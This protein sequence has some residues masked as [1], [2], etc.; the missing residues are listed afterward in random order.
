VEYADV[1]KVTELDDSY[2][3]VESVVVLEN[4]RVGPDKEAN[5]EASGLNS[6]SC[7][8]SYN[9]LYTNLDN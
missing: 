6:Y 2:T 1:Y 5:T 7:C 8:W 9:H 4:V 3:V